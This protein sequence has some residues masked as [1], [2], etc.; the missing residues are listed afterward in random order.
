MATLALLNCFAHVHDHDFTTD[1]NQLNLNVEVTALDKTTFGSSG[2]TE[3][4]GGLKD[5]TFDMTGFWQSGFASVDQDQDRTSFDNLSVRNHAHTVGPVNTEANPAYMF[6][7][8]K[9][10]Y[11]LLGNINEMA[12][13]TLNS[14]NTDGVGAVRGQLAAKK[15]NVSTVGTFGS[16]VNL[17][18]GSA[19]KFLYATLHA[20]G[21][22]TTI[23]IDIE[24]APTSAFVALDTTTRATIGPI[25]ARGGTWVPRVDA[26][27]ITDPW[28]RF[29]VTAVT[30]TFSVAGA[31]AIQ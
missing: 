24:S 31:I 11:N 17:G 30:G 4:A 10:T 28:W 25:T 27:A 29:N 3:L 23:T 13:F 14:R 21:V 1:T 6:R 26:S 19:G 18:A 15:Q 16:G 22:G 2:W 20:F 5:L 7:A 8:G 9:F 12:P